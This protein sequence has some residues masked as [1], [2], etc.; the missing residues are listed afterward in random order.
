MAIKEVIANAAQGKIDE[1]R[2]SVNEMLTVKAIEALEQKKQQ[3]GKNFFGSVNEAK[4][5][6]D[7]AIPGGNY[8]TK[9]GKTKAVT[10]KD[11]DAVAVSGG[12]YVT[13]NGKTKFV[14]EEQ[15]DEVSKGTLRSYISK[16]V[17]DQGERMKDDNRDRGKVKAKF[18]SRHS[19]IKTAAAKLSGRARVPVSEEQINEISKD[20]LGSYVKKAKSDMM[21]KHSEHEQDFGRMT[22]GGKQTLKGGSATKLRQTI[23]K[24]SKGIDKAVDKLVG[25]A[26]V[27]GTNPQPSFKGKKYEHGM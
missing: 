5:D 7:I 6:V 13:R 9:N 1:M 24:R 26:K 15:I 27:P 12:A 11:K 16:A 25:T 23:A 22:A 3:V 4:S 21:V 10:V 8:V 19:G 2:S 18:D 17:S 14:K 20:T